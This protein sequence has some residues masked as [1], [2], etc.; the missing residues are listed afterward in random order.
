MNFLD[1]LA[2]AE[3]QAF[4]AVARERTFARGARLMREGEQ[5]AYVMVILTGWTQITV[6]GN[7]GEQVVA[8]RGPGQLVGECGAL[9]LDARSAT[10]TALATVR[11]LVMRCEDFASF[12]S[13]HPRVLEAVEGQAC[14]RL[15]EDA[16]G[17]TCDRL[18]ENAE[19]YG[20][21]GRPG[22]FRAA[23]CGCA[24]DGSS[25]PWPP[26]GEN[27]TVLLTDVVGFGAV[28]RNDRD[29]Q[30]IRREGLEMMRASM[31]SLWEACI[32]E[33][34]G[35]GLLIVVPPCVPTTRIL[36]RLERELPGNLDLHNR[37]HSESARIRLRIAVNV[38]P[39][40]G[41]SLG[42]S[43]EAIIRT[44]RMVEAP[45]FKGA[46]AATGAGLGIIVSPFVHEVAI[47]Q[48]SDSIKANEY[49]PVEVSL[50]E[51]TSTAWMRLVDQKPA[52]LP[53]GLEPEPS[54]G[55]QPGN[56]G[57]RRSGAEPRLA[58][59]CARTAAGL[60]EQ[61]GSHVDARPWS[62]AACRNSDQTGSR[63]HGRDRGMIGT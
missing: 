16:E 17:Q 36:E 8:E 5:P 24:M 61:G 56:R 19:G 45:A 39:V 60:I 7:G 28:T 38:G 20:Q 27:C 62:V 18:T 26:A 22:M 48:A 55:C 59:A 57:G 49:N 21:H 35:D 32:S 40:M 47:S 29:R 15:A 54:R 3:R 34:R 42:M 6:Q 25:H 41:D 50:K 58:S 13:A 14:D 11:A 33:D 23:L 2:P 1:S 10:V 52:S 30:I 4:T 53:A 12:L 37:S 46:M 63:G 9:R 51:F 43:G 31:G 44:A